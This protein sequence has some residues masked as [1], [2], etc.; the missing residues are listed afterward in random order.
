MKLLNKLEN[1]FEAKKS[2]SYIILFLVS[3]FL[4]GFLHFD[5]TFADPDSFYHVKSAQFLFERGSITSF[6]WLNFT[7]LKY[8]FTDHHFLYHL[9]L[10]PFVFGLPPLWGIKVATVFFASLAV[11]AFC[12]LL[13]SLRVK[14]AFWYSLFLLTINPFVFRLGLAKA[15]GLVILF[16]FILLYLLFNRKYL[17]LMFLSCLYVWLYAGWPLTIFICFVYGLLFLIWPRKTTILSFM[18]WNKIKPFKNFVL[19][20]FG[21][22]IGSLAGVLFSP[23][24]PGNLHFYYQQTFQI[25]LVNYQYVID[26]GG[27]WYPYEI[28][29]LLTAAIPFFVLTIISVFAFLSSYKKQTINSWFAFIMSFIFFVLTLKSRRYV[30][31]L[32]PF[33]VLFSAVTL[34]TFFTINQEWFKKYF[35]KSFLLVLPA[36]LLLGISPLAARDINLVKEFYSS[37]FSFNKFSRAST[38][39]RI[40][41]EPGDLVFHSDWDEFPI[42]F[43]NN[44]I[45]Y[46][47]VGLDP[48]FMYNYD[49]ELHRQWV[50]ITRGENAAGMYDVIKNVFGAKYVF[51]D[52]NQ[53]IGFDNNL[54]NNIFFEKAYEDEE[55]RIYRV[56]E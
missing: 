49:S 3:V 17:Q 11:V 26:V 1:Y 2:R 8:N 50:E 19:L 12:F 43:Y 44:D 7:E 40:N 35:S 32:V 27:E 6:P 54:K 25:A 22:T 29:S 42:L 31:Y 13:R 37:A 10:A 4:F 15:Q 51:V 46:Y 56:L 30:E 38:W 20:M 36:L 47:I 55:A 14:G 9:L 16:L 5:A 28:F 41:S 52:I 45:N 18:K 23:Y 48:T 34:N 53:N 24:F 33:S 39:L 21:V